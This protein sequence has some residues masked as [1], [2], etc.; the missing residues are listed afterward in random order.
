MLENAGIATAKYHKVG[1]HE[2]TLT[3]NVSNIQ[4]QKCPWHETLLSFPFFTIANASTLDL[5]VIS[6]FLLAL[7]VLPTLQKT[8]RK[9][10][11]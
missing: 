2:S 3:T 10:S 6:T 9:Y 4:A 5:Q 8:S 7:L 1:G 11:K